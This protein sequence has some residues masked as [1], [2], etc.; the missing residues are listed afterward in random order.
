[1]K[2]VLAAI[3]LASVPG[4]LADK[5]TKSTSTARSEAHSPTYY[6]SN[7]KYEVDLNLSQGQ[8]HNYKLGNNSFT[9]INI[10]GAFHMAL[11]DNLQVGGEVGLFSYRETKGTGQSTKTLVQLMGVATYNL[12]PDFKNSVFVEAG[13]GLAPAYDKTDGSY[14]SKFSFFFDVGKR[15]AIWDHIAYKPEFRL[16]KYGDQDIEFLVLGLNVSASF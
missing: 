8:I 6:G 12:E 7:Y 13:L 3:I 16:S 9:D 1:M 14:G 10:G 2:Y 15:F 11:Q 4:A 5:K